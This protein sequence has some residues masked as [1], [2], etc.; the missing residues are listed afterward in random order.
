MAPPEKRLGLEI[1]PIK[2]RMTVG[3]A[4]KFSLFLSPLIPP[5]LAMESVSLGVSSSS[6]QAEDPCG[7]KARLC[8]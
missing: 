2:G 5:L 4:D 7:G 8:G 3:G 6:V 1:L